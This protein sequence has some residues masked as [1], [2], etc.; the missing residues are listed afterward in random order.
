[1]STVVVSVFLFGALVAG[2]YQALRLAD[3][4]AALR[5]E[6]ERVERLHKELDEAKKLTGDF[7]RV[8]Q[9]FEKRCTVAED[10]REDAER[11][12]AMAHTKAL[13]LEH[14]RDHFQRECERLK[15]LSSS[16]FADVSDEEM[17]NFI[18]YDGTGKGQREVGHA[19]E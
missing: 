13:A 9:S 6:R 18:V 14:D 11:R 19:E 17:R 15:S 10:A 5:R 7:Q 8:A 16:P 1:M 3:V 4:Q 12:A 2:V